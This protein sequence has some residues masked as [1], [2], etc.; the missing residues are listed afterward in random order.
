VPLSP[1]KR[2]TKYIFSPNHHLGDV[3]SDPAQE[4]QGE[5]GPSSKLSQNDEKFPGADDAHK[6]Y[7]AWQSHDPRSSS[8]QSLVPSSRDNE[9]RRTLM[10]VYIHG[11]MG[12][13]SSFR[14]FPAHIHNF[15]KEA[16][17]ETHIV[18]TKI[19]PRYKTYKSIDVARDNFSKWIEPHESP[20][21]DVVLVGHS[22]GGLL[23]ADIALIVSAPIPYPW[24]PYNPAVGRPWVQWSSSVYHTLY[25]H[26]L[27]L[28][29]A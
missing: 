26:I 10:M 13:D 20:T 17:A 12:N 19:Y 11:F 22:M 27:M 28:Y 24:S 2:P 21:T 23:A 6:V 14:S 15:L 25:V 18:H 5:G 29:V 4:V 8:T 7:R 9:Q 3:M 1:R 16:L